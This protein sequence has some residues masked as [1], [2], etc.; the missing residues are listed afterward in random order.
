MAEQDPATRAGL[1]SLD[2]LARDL[3]RLR[4]EAGA[5]SYAEIALRIARQRQARGVPADEAR[6]GRTTVYDAFRTGRRRIN[7]G[8]VLEIVRA[9]GAD[10]AAVALWADRCRAVHLAAVAPSP[11]TVPAGDPQPADA[12]AERPEE[13]AEPPVARLIAWRPG[14]RTVLAIVVGCVA[15]NLVGR[16]IVHVLHMSIYLD[17]IGTAV[18]AVVLGPWWGALVGLI[19]NTAGVTTSG[20]ASLPFALVNVAGALVWG[21]GVRRFGMGRTVPRFFLLNLGVAVTCSLMAVP[22]LVLLYGGSVGHGE[23]RIVA[24][25]EDIGESLVPAVLSANLVTSLVDKMIAGFVAVMALDVVRR[26]VVEPAD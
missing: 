20:A 6:L 14:R 16:V 12:P 1:T 13:P 3:Q 24:R 8:L 23:D 17:M 25:F 21:Y 11:Q 9:L 5:P 19:T 4:A 22:I 7:T 2:E 10:D 15:L 26:R 18:S